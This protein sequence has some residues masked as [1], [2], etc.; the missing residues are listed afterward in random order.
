MHTFPRRFAF[1]LPVAEVVRLPALVLAVVLGL[2]PGGSVRADEA[3]PSAAIGECCNFEPSHPVAGSLVICGGGKLPALVLDRFLKLAGGE[4]A[5]IVVIPTA[6]ALAGTPEV[7]KK[8]E[9]LRRAKLAALNILHTRSRTTAD[10][11]AFVRPLEKATGVWF[12]GGFQWRLADTYLGTAVDRLVHA[13]LDRGGVVGGTSSGAAIMS[14][15]MIRR[16]NPDPEVGRGFDFLSGTVIDQHFIKRQRQGRLVH[17]LASHPGYVGLG[18]DEGTALVAQGRRLRVIGDSQVIAC[19]SAG[20][21]RPLRMQVLKS[22]DEVDLIA[23]SRAAIARARPARPAP[24]TPPRVERGSL[25]I[26]GGGRTPPEAVR[27]F[28]AAAGGPDAP[29]VVV[30]TAQ[31]QR[32]ADAEAIGW[33]L[34]AGARRVRQL[35]TSDRHQASDPQVLAML[36][37]ARGIWFDGGRQWRLVD[38]YLD[39]EAQ[40]LFQQVLERGGVIGGTSA[41]ATIQAG[42]L[43]RGSP[44]GNTEVIAEGYE[45]GFGFLRGV[46]IDQHFSQRSRLPDMAQVRARHPELV[47]L[48]LDE[49]TALIVRGRECQVVGRGSVSVFARAA[50]GA[51]AVPPREILR[52]GD[53]YD[54]QA[55]RV[56]HAA[57][58]ASV[59]EAK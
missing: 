56:Q 15:L 32:P 50:D 24:P 27:Q 41:G 31:A 44:L 4:R 46:A 33:L 29:L 16:S 51:S 57:N 52:A 26:V 38:A 17:V 21:S 45:R 3:D 12:T 34:K 49:D 22:G 6:S 36:A 28:I 39:T 2:L 55:A 10:D 18:I 14:T 13:V 42:Y 59:A 9:F 40:H 48:G 58:S 35:F 54:F 19:L 1:Q 23:L 5:R 47:G 7:E 53:R 37:A 11:P 30:T 43:L 8:L 25:V 20:P